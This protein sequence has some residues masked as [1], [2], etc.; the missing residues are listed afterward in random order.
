MDNEHVNIALLTAMLVDIA[1]EVYAVL[2]SHEAEQA[3][4]HFAPDLVLLDLDMARLDGLELLRRL[5]SARDTA[6]FP[7]V[8]VLTEAERSIERIVAL[9]LGADDFLTKPLDRHEVVV[10]VRNHLKTR[11][12][13][14]EIRRAGGSSTSQS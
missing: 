11:H 8:I 7:T 2:D 14:E 12:L 13:L 3:F 6:G 4:K 5:Q 10:R 9:K 1:D